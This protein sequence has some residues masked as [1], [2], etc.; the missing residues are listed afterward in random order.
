MGDVHTVV[1]KSAGLLDVLRIICRKHTQLEYAH[2]A[3]PRVGVV[4]I[5]TLAD[6]RI[7]TPTNASGT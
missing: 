4:R 1:D 5:T 2:L 7:Q 3:S 6:Y